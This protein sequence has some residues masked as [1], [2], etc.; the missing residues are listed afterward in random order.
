VPPGGETGTGRAVALVRIAPGD[1]ER[2]GGGRSW[3]GLVVRGAWRGAGGVK[4]RIVDPRDEESPA[5]GEN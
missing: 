1:T 4:R 5:F 3:P 2:S